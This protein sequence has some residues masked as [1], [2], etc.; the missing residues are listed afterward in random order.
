MM[1]LDARKV[2]ILQ[3]VVQDFVD[4][5]RPVGSER[6]LEVYN[7]GCKSATERYEMAEMAEM[8]YLAQPHTSSG[9][10]P[11]DRGYRYFVN[12]L[13]EPPGALPKEDEKRA[14]ADLN[15]TTNEIDDIIQ[16]T[17]RILSGLTSYASV[18][19]DPVTDTT[20]M[21]RLYLTQASPRHV[22]AVALFSTGAVEHRLVEVASA[23]TDNALLP[24]SNLLNEQIANQPIEDVD[25]LIAAIV[26]PAEL[27]ELAHVLSHVGS[28]LLRVISSLLQRRV[29]LQG[30]NQLM[31]QPEFQD[32]MRLEGLLTALEQRS[33]LFRVLRQSLTGI[34]VTIHIGAEN[35]YEPMRECTLISR[36]YS[37]GNRHAGY[38]GV[39]GPTRMHY[40][41][42]ISAVN[43]MS[44]NL[45][46]MLT[47][48]CVD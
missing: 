48:M 40:Q 43:F 41:R 36:P 33:A 4:T 11:T 2:R 28:A 8:G 29:Y 20:R 42:T 18:A 30:A 32:V 26:L 38:L 35:P 31:R 9:R 24:L 45:S 44:A 23:P 3:A 1:P 15:R 12:E 25:R 22:L 21:R 34:G 16:Q 13:M 39:V 7:L 46:S 19:T 14:R 17:C 47:S 37:I 10:I 5:S 6:L 27:A